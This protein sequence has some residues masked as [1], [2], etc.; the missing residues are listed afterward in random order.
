MHD[1]PVQHSF[2]PAVHAC[3]AVEQVAGGV[4]TPPV[5]VS[6]AA[7]LQQ[8]ESSAQVWPVW[9]QLGPAAVQVP[10][11]APGGTSQARPAQ[12]SA[13]TVHAPA[14]GMQTAMQTWASTSHA[15]EQHWLSY[16]QPFPF[17][18][19]RPQVP[20]AAPGVDGTHRPEQQASAGVAGAVAHVA[21][22]ATHWKSSWQ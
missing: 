13:F 7:W 12:Q 2:P 17:G 18:A 1:R 5:Q 11:V 14:A 19:H 16:A 9:A 4:Q 20:V 8:S 15:P 10:L 3:A 6:P 21:P 22:S